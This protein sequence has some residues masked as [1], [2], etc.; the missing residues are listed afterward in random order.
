MTEVSPAVAHDD[1]PTPLVSIVTPAYNQ[2]QYLRETIESVLKQRFQNIEYIVIDDGSTDETPAILRE[3]S[4]QLTGISRANKG[5]ARTLNEGWALAKGK[6]IGYLSSDDILYPNAIE[7]LLKR[8]ER[9]PDIVCVYPDC[10]LIDE[11]SRVIKKNTCKHFDLEDLLI[12]QECYIGPGAVFRRDAFEAVGGWKPELRLA[13]DREFWIRL[14]SQG[15]IVFHEEIL[16]G[17]R[18]HTGSISYKDVSEAVG[19]EYILVLDQFFSQPDIPAGLAALKD[20]AYGRATLILARNCFRA[21]E[22]RRGLQ[23]YREAC[24]LHQPLASAT[25]KAQ[26][27][28]NVVSKPVRM[29]LS[30]LRSWSK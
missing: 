27:I 25:V 21:A 10:E 3:Y 23:L 11:S 24:A 7:S 6:Y 17:Y 16:A 14:A 30:K 13:P 5:Q 19:R 22:F 15:R 18:L 4:Q 28:R 1:E 29:A 20:E 12:R 9:D 26:L 2:G 8:I